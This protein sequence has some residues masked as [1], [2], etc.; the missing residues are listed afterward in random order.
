MELFRPLITSKT[1][2]QLRALKK[3]K[4]SEELY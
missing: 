2:S 1:A 3:F 4:R